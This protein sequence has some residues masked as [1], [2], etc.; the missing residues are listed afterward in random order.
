MAIGP[1]E[2]VLLGANLGR[3]IVTNG[4][5]TAYVCDSSLL[6]NYFAQTCYLRDGLILTEGLKCISSVFQ[7]L[8]QED[9]SGLRVTSSERVAIVVSVDSANDLDMTQL[10]P[11]SRW[12]AEYLHLTTYPPPAAQSFRVLGNGTHTHTSQ[13]THCVSKK[14]PTFKLSVIL[15][16]L[17]RFSK[18]LHCWKACEICY[19]NHTNY[20]PHLRHVATLP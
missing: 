16:N 17:N 19:K 2:G 13:T 12:H 15:S 20:P 11:V 5:F 14:V 4:D 9:V 1:R 10:P 7:L 18:F 3:T 8:N 6:P